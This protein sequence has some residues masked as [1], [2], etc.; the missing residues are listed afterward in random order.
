MPLPNINHDLYVVNGGAKTQ[1]EEERERK[2]SKFS[3][4]EKETRNSGQFVLAAAVL[5]HAG[6][7]TCY[8]LYLHSLFYLCRAAKNTYISSSH[9]KRKKERGMIVGFEKP[10]PRGIWQQIKNRKERKWR[11]NFICCTRALAS[12]HVSS[13]IQNVWY[14]VYPISAIHLSCDPVPFLHHAIFCTVHV[15]YMHVHC[16]LYV[17]YAQWRVLVAFALS[18]PLGVH[19]ALVGC[20]VGSCMEK[21]EERKM[22]PCT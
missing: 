6:G 22:L 8:A 5:Q 12:K 15:G 4:K 17:L 2:N 19:C 16:T 9:R 1:K 21:K 3:I 11:L 14:K 7:G 10:T 20:L 13:F 18:A